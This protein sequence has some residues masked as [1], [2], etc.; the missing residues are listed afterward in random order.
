MIAFTGPCACTKTGFAEAIS[1]V[2]MQPGWT[3]FVRMPRGAGSSAAT[4][5][6]ATA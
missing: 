6:Y 5:V 4:F 2:S 3:T 1:G